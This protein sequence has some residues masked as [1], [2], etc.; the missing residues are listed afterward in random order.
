[1]FFFMVY[2]QNYLKLFYFST[3]CSR[4]K[5]GLRATFQYNERCLSDVLAKKSAVCRLQKFTVTACNSHTTKMSNKCPLNGIFAL[6]NA[7]S[8]FKFVRTV[9]LQLPRHSGLNHRQKVYSLEILI[10]F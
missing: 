2:D 7:I 9:F 4:L 6:N 8:C 1:M 10:I 5:T 3:T